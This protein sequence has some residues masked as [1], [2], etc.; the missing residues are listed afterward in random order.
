MYG[1]AL[2]PVGK[3]HIPGVILSAGIAPQFDQSYGWLQGDQVVVLLPDGEARQFAYNRH[4]FELEPEPIMDPELARD[5]L[6][7]VLMPA[8]LYSQQRHGVLTR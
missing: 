5:A 7:N 6:A 3:F 4:T 2:V 1:D 8:W